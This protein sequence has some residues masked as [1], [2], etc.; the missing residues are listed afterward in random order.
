MIFHDSMANAQEKMT[1]VCLFLE[2]YHLPP[3]PMNYHVAYTYISKCDTALN[4][5]LDDAINSKKTIDSIYIENLYFEYLNPGHKTETE[6]LQSVDGIL[7]N[8]SKTTHESHKQ[9][10]SFAQSI[11][12]C[13]QTLDEGN[14]AKSRKAIVQLSQTTED[15]LQQHQVFKA[16]MK[17]ARL[18]YVKSQQQ[19]QQLRR[20]HIIDPQTGLYKRHYLNQQTQAW[21]AKDKSICAIAIQITN[22]DDFT[23]QYGDLVGDVVLNR[24][25]KKV[26][27]YV[28]ESG[29]P[30]RTR[31]QEFTVLLADIEPSTANVIAE[32]IKKGVDRLKFVS[33]KGNKEL[34]KIELALGITKRYQEQN[35]DELAHK[36]HLAAHKAHLCGQTSF[37]AP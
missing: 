8:L 35:F 33:T 17:K 20:Q 5:A 24:V 21:M 6:L 37:I 31:K 1:Q 23:Q 11:S 28:F 10:S 29:L 34:P 4:K 12:T 13:I 7:T 16:Q 19:L 9:I 36:A 30:G 32:K 18:M 26:Q 22:L 2:Q 15:L 3:T 25:A 27:K 14:V